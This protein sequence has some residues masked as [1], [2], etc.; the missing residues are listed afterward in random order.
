[1]E[2]KNLVIEEVMAEMD[3]QQLGWE[4]RWS[5]RIALA[6]A[7]EQGNRKDGVYLLQARCRDKIQ[8]VLRSAYMVAERSQE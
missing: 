2:L 8:L 1:M 3:R 7:L 5:D 6:D 4:L